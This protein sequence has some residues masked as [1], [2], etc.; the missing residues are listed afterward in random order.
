M[1]IITL[2]EDGVTAVNNA[3]CER[4]L[5]QMMEIKMKSEKINDSLNRFHVTS[6]VPGDNKGGP[7]VHTADG[8]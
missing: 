4:L 1:T 6:P 3:A 5:N 7:S 8:S 2:T